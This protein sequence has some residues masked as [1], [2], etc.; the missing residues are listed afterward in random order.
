MTWSTFK[1]KVHKSTAKQPST[2]LK[3]V[4]VAQN[5]LQGLAKAESF[6]QPKSCVQ[7][8]LG[9]A[10]GSPTHPTACISQVSREA[11]FNSSKT[12]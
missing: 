5:T 8:T 4:Q 3:R 6:E 9:H 10:L 1:L 12:Y 7:H 11:N 2:C